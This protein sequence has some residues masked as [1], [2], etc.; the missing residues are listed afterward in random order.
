MNVSENGLEL[1]KQFE[2]C[3][4]ESYQDSVGVWTIG[5]GSTR[6]VTEGMSIT[7]EEAD[8]RLADDVVIAVRC[9]N[10]SAPYGITQNQ[11][12]SLVSFVFNLGCASL[13]NST[14][15]RKLKEGDEVGA[16]NEF[17]KWAHARGQVLVGLVRRREAEKELFLA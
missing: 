8:D 14:L 13:R 5:Y 15:L 7:Q 6:G 11:F 4:L 10:Q 16:A 2:G 1:I 9:V 12:D 17:T 3:E